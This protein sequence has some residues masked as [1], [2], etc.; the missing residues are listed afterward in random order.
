MKT[1]A[2]V[3][4]RNSRFR[5]NY[6]GVVI[7]GVAKASISESEHASNTLYGLLVTDC[8]TSASADI[9]VEGSTAHGNTDGLSL[10]ASS[11]AGP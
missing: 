6:N 11:V 1:G 5:A 8:Y 9:P 2:Q 7:S 3:S 10:V 4:I